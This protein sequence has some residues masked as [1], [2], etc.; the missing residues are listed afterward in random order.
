MEAF[1]SLA[2]T[3][4]MPQ[5]CKTNS[6]G[7]GTIEIIE[8]KMYFQKSNMFPAPSPAMQLERHR[9]L[10][11]G[12][13][14]NKKHR[15][16]HELHQ[17]H[18][19]QQQHHCSYHHQR[20]NRRQHHHNHHQQQKINLLTTISIRIDINFITININIIIII[21]YHH[22]VFLPFCFL[23]H[24]TSNVGKLLPGPKASSMRSDRRKSP[25]DSAGIIFKQ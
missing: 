4:Q 22:H 25:C 23:L 10:T 9:T 1:Q 15:C 8:H 19:H 3:K 18:Q 6:N 14:D 16:Y 12:Q 5:L 24:G 11:G 13:R 17:R 7:R 20:Q 2:N 21:I